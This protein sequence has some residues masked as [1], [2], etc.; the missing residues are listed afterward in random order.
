ME[1]HKLAIQAKGITKI[2]PND[3]IGLHPLSLDIESKSF[4]AL[5]GPSGCGKSTLLKC[6]NGDNPATSGEVFIN[7]LS[8]ID[9]YDL[10][11]K[12]IGYVPQEDIIHRELSVYKTLFYAAK[13]RLPDGTSQEEIDVRINKVL[14]SLKLDQHDQGNPK[15]QKDI[16]QK[17][18]KELSG[19]QRKRIS[20]AVEL[21]TEP[22]ILFLDEPTSPLDPETI[23]S[24]LKSLRALTEEG[25]SIIMVTHKPEDLNYVDEVVFLGVNGHLVYK[26]PP[27]KITTYFKVDSIIEVYS[28]MSDLEGVKKQYIAPKQD[29]LSLKTNAKFNKSKPDSSFRQ[30]Y[31]LAARYL[32]IKLNDYSNLLLLLLQPIIIGGLVSLVFSEFRIG[33]I[34]LTSISAIWFGVSNSA[35]EIVSE[36]PIY[37]RERMF[38]LNINT[39]IVSKLLILALIAMVQVI[40][41]VSIIYLNFKINAIQEFPETYLRPFWESVGYLFLVSCSATLIGL[42]LSSYF[43]TTEKV[44]TVVPITLMPQIM[45]AGVMTKLDTRFIEVLSFFTLGRWGTE[46]FS[47]LQD[48]YFKNNSLEQESVLVPEFNPD[49][50]HKND[51][52]CEAASALDQL[53]LYDTDLINDGVLIGNTFNTIHANILAILVLSI[54]MYL[55]IFISL[56]KKDSI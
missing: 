53:G 56:N 51:C 43:N 30:L 48:G 11:K 5:M 29:V 21:L 36:L 52:K 14:K 35:K 55:L 25:T 41:F 50:Y 46:G 9:H 1:P 31:W 42:F 40:V 33:V 17:K 37:K 32:K 22:T 4:V 20:I 49:G 34:F 38:N 8:L 44:M 28:R 15:G 45:L 19:G 10:V 23:D 6:L 3:K 18:V 54:I 13:L 26:G 24:F 2:Y 39:Y 16:K 47:R 12:S 27:T 7:G